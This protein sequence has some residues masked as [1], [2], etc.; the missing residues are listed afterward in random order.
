MQKILTVL[1]TLM[2][3]G[4]SSGPAWSA[5]S[6]KGTGAQWGSPQDSSTTRTKPVKK[7]GKKKK[8]KTTAQKKVDS[9]RYKY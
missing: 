5:D 2:F 6:R 8:S 9:S 3:L 4:L 1:F 7:K